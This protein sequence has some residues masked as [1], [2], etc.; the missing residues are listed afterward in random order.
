MSH[1]VPMRHICSILSTALILAVLGASHAAAEAPAIIPLQG[2]LLDSEGKP[3]DGAHRLTFF[4]YDAATDG[5]SV[6]T[7]NYNSVDVDKGHFVVYLGN[8]ED[9]PLDLGLFR[10]HRDLWVEVVIDG[11]ETV[12]P[13]TYLASVPYAG[14][15]Q[16]CGDAQTLDGRPSSDLVPAGALMPFAGSKAPAGWLLAD[17]SEVSRATYPAL[18]AAIGTTYGGGGNGSKTFRLPDLR[19]RTAVGAGAGSGLTDRALGQSFGSENHTLTAAQLPGHTHSGATSSG[20]AMFYR[21]VSPCEGS[22]SSGN[23]VRGWGGCDTY[24]DRTDNQ[25]AMANHTHDFT[26]DSGSGLNGAAHPIVQP[27]MALTY[28]IKY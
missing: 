6:Y 15:A 12:A 19:G 25:Y 11:S 13:R 23:H 22:E 18:F 2:Y 17:G 27:S 14:F 3:V 21:T 8:Q 16:A 24:V 1:E 4:L 20:N 5:D 7:D 28:I 26:T 9:A 10:E